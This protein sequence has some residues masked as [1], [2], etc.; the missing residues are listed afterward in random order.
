MK[1]GS[2]AARLSRSAAA[3]AL[4]SVIGAPALAQQNPAQTVETTQPTT[5][6]PAEESSDRV[7]V[8]GSRLANQFSSAAPMDVIVAEE[9]AAQGISD[10]ASLLRSTTVAAGSPQI[11]AVTSTAFVQD[12]GVGAET[13]SLRG[14]GANRTLVL[15][16]GRRAGPAGTRGSVGAFDFNVLPL[17]AIERVEILKEGASSIYGSDAIAGVIN[18]IT[19]TGDGADFDMFYSAPLAGG[20]DQFRINGS[21]GETFNNNLQVR[22]TADYFNQKELARG[23]RDFFACGAPYVF[24]ADGSRADLVDPRTG[25]Y[26]CS[27]DLPWGH[28]WYYDYNE[29]GAITRPWQAR[30]QLIQYNYGNNLQNWLPGF[31]PTTNPATFPPGWFPVGY[32][33]LNGPTATPDPFYGASARLSEALINFHHPFQDQESL[34]PEIERMTLMGKMEFDFNDSAQL[35]A[36]ALLNRRMTKVN[37]YRQ[38]WT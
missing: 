7:V 14:L 4:V 12:G 15:L 20:G 10:V 29:P 34:S 1:F 26:T 19:K 3:G 33:E 38:L 23:D 16:D 11:T 9:A 22:V 21:W 30:P 8:T 28:I 5:T 24:R 25:D 27:S 18:I 32:G 13:I 17:S 2:L 6:A 35:Y 37:S 36:E 31:G